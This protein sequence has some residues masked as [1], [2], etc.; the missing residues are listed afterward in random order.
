MGV[1]CKAKGI[2]KD[3]RVL[4]FEKYLIFY[5]FDEACNEVIILRILYGSRNYHVLLK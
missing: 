4:I 1:S 2:N 3:C 5:K